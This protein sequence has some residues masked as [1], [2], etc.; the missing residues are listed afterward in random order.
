MRLWGQILPSSELNSFFAETERK[1]RLNLPVSVL[2]EAD[3]K[4]ILLWSS[5]FLWS[6]R[7]PS[8][9]SQL[10]ANSFSP[11]A[12]ANATHNHT[13]PHPRQLLHWLWHCER[14]ETAFEVKTW[15]SA[16]GCPHAPLPAQRETHQ[17]T[18]RAVTSVCWKSLPLRQFLLI[19][20]QLLF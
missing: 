14:A 15:G 7:N 20:I 9:S 1:T 2:T 16:T 13:A 4:V 10:T 6:K 11:K 17:G 8:S 19:L 5:P 12:L 3:Q 18:L